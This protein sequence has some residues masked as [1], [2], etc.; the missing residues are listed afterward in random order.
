[1]R[2]R[3]HFASSDLGAV[4]PADYTFTAADQGVHTFSATLK[5]AGSQS[6]TASDTVIASAGTQAN[7]TVKPAAASRFTVADFPSPV[8]AG[9]AGSFT[10]TARDPYGNLASGYTDTV[11]FTSSDPRASLPGNYTFTAADAG[12]HTFSATFKTAGYQSLIATDTANG[13]LTGAQL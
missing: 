7:I 3:V 13:A 6:I 12:V 4:L 11:R 8:T 10:V 2:G 9:A 5:R 1:Y